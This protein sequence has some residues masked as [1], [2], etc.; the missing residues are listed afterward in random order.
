MRRDLVAGAAYAAIAF[1]FGVVLGALRVLVVAPAL[2][3]ASAV[4][5]EL[6]L[7]L[8]VSWVACGW[9]ERR[10]AVPR[11]TAARLRMGMIAFVL[12][13]AA[14]FWLG[15][16]AFGRGPAEQLD[17]LTRGPGL[18]GLLAQFAFAAMPWVRLRRG[19]R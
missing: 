12:L 18:A 13:Q 3:E 11:A 4:A 19:A 2:G 8:A 10:V 6:P 17:A 7:M 16:A 15:L 9:V 5:L 14:E 1:A